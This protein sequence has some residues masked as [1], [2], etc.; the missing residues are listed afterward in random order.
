[1]I[2]PVEIR[3]RD[4][5]VLRGELIR[6]SADWAVLVHDRGDDLDGWGDLRFALATAGMTVLAYDLRGHGGA[7]GRSSA[8]LDRRDLEDVLSFARGR[9]AQRIFLAAV[10][11]SVQAALS[12]AAGASAL[13]AIDPPPATLSCEPPCPALIFVP[14][15]V[16]RRR[17]A[18]SSWPAVHLPSRERGHELLRGEWADHVQEH[19]LRFLFQARRALEPPLGSP[20]R[21]P[22]RHPPARAEETLPGRRGAP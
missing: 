6:S 9:G 22:A 14:G 11:R 1:M 12:A 20:T 8:A 13:V 10:G 17:P 7:E 5:T 4:G 18:G 3:A 16:S 2:E 19:A 21:Q 15:V